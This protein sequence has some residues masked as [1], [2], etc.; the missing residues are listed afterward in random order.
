[1]RWRS[2]GVRFA[3]LPAAESLATAATRAALATPTFARLRRRVTVR[4]CRGTILR[5]PLSLWPRRS[6]S[7]CRPPP[8][9]PPCRAAGASGWLPPP[10]AA[11]ASPRPRPPAPCPRV[12]A[13]RRLETQRRIHVAR[14]TE[15]QRGV[16]NA[17]DA[18]RARRS[19]PH[20][21]R[22][23]G[24]EPEVLVHHL[25]PHRIGD[26]VVLCGRVQAHGVDGA[27]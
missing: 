26:D 18:R 13:G 24:P 11:C 8:C 2:S 7:A 1:M 9:C 14:R 17:H 25:D 12:G 6:V 16:R 15:T 22:Q 19:N 27:R 10:G 23:R 21:G 20:G 4:A 3:K 5:L